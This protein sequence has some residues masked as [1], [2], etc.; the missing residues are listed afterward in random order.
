M[1]WPDAPSNA[2]RPDGGVRETLPATGASAHCAKAG[3]AAGSSAA[4]QPSDSGPDPRRCPGLRAWGVA[5]NGV[6][7]TGH[8]GRIRN[9]PS[10]VP[11]R[12]CGAVRGEHPQAPPS[13]LPQVQQN[14]RRRGFTLRLNP[15]S[16]LAEARFQPF[17]LLDPVSRNM[18]GVL[19]GGR[20]RR[21]RTAKEKNGVKVIRRDRDDM[22]HGES[23]FAGRPP[24]WVR[25]SRRCGGRLDL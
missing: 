1:L 21:R 25:P 2:R 13:G 5:D 20:F 11:S 12:F 7:G 18:S 4:Q 9:R 19:R 17:G 8:A 14:D 10:S 23:S 6:P 22:T 16:C 15:L 3:S 24:G